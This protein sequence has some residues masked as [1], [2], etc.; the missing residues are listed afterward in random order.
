MPYLGTVSNGADGAEIH[1][2]LN[3]KS[4]YFPCTGPR[5]PF[6]CANGGLITK[7][8]AERISCP[9]SRDSSRPCFEFSAPLK[10]LVCKTKIDDSKILFL[11]SLGEPFE[12]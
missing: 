8:L 3:P 9:D 7:S 2:C 1:S 11:T 6:N 5:L 12:R 10:L 4:M